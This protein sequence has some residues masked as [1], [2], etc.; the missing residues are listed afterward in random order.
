MGGVFKSHEAQEEPEQLVLLHP[1]DWLEALTLR[2]CSPKHQSA[3]TVTYM[4]LF[5]LILPLWDG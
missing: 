3:E 2:S 1:K 4:M 5:W